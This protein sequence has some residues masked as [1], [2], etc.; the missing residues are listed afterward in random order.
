MEETAAGAL[1]SSLLIS[2]GEAKHIIAT[3]KNKWEVLGKPRFFLL[4]ESKRYFLNGPRVHRISAPG[5]PT[6]P[7]GFVCLLC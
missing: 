3:P 7:G 5:L 4:R 1:V 6:P 2:P